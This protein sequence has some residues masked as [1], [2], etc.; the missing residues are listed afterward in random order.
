MARPRKSD[1]DSIRAERFS[2]SLTP[3][4][5]SDVMTLAA[6]RDVS[7]NEFLICFIATICDKNQAVIEQFRAARQRAA[8][9]VDLSL[10]DTHD[11]EDVPVV[12]DR[13]DEAVND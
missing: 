12:D 2:L 9:A 7:V 11:V 4:L 6:I 13:A 5:Y 10:D 8:E 3:K 1:R